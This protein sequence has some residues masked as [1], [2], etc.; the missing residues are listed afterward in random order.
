MLVTLLDVSAD[1]AAELVELLVELVAVV[2]VDVLVAAR[3]SSFSR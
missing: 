3:R 2:A 1:V